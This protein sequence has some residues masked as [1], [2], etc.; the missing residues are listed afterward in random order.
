MPTWCI[1]SPQGFIMER[2]AIRSWWGEG[3]GGGC[4]L[5]CTECEAKNA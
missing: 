4:A 5:S 2:V 3:A 1:A